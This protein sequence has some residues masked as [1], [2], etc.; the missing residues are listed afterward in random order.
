MQKRLLT[1]PLLVCVELTVNKETQLALHSRQV[2]ALG[3]LIQ[4]NIHIQVQSKMLAVIMALADINFLSF[5]RVAD[6]VLR[7]NLFKSVKFVSKGKL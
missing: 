6:I 7:I 4:I 3:F 1:K 5:A 2:S